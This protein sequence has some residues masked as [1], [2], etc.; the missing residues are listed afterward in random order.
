MLCLICAITYWQYW[1][2]VRLV[3]YDIVAL[4]FVVIVGVRVLKKG[5]PFPVNRNLQILV[6]LLLSF[7]SIAVL[8]GLTII[9]SP[10]GPTALSQYLKTTISLTA[11][12]VFQI[13]VLVFLEDLDPARRDRLLNLYLGGILASC[14]FEFVEIALATRGIDLI[15]LVFDPISVLPPQEEGKT[16]IYEWDNFVRG[17]GFAGT[18]AQAAYIV[19]GLPLLLTKNVRQKSLLTYL[20]TCIA[21]IALLLTMSRGGIISASVVILIM[22]AYYIGKA[23]WIVGAIV[24]VA[25]P[26]YAGY[27]I[28]QHEILSLATSRVEVD[29]SRINMWL[30][31]LSVFAKAPWGIGQGQYGVMFL[32]S[33]VDTAKDANIHNN[34]LQVLVELGLVGF[35]CQIAMYLYLIWTLARMRTDLSRIALAGT[36]G[37]MC[38]AM[39]SSV[40]TNFYSNLF[41][42]LFYACAVLDQREQAAIGSH[43]PSWRAPVRRSRTRVN[44]WGAGP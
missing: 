44:A 5:R 34:Y 41:V 2:G 30:D 25:A 31:G 37:L 17:N 39:F 7:W 24:L 15:R 29:G 1:V 38:A 12:V 11:Y 8:S 18:N 10:I 4:L 3:I 23:P 43:G 33:S 13:L 27:I 32:T 20:W 36:V 40:L 35:I 14:T 21:L 22:F 19:S 16:A 9:V 26:L 42:V 6:F 28:Y